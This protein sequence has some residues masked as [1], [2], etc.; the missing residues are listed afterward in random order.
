MKLR[1]LPYEFKAASIAA[2]VSLA[3]L[4]AI[5]Y[6]PESQRIEPIKVEGLNYTII[7]GDRDGDVDKIIDLRKPQNPV[8]YV[9]EDMV[10]W[11]KDNGETFIDYISRPPIPTPQLLE[12]ANAI[13]RG[14]SDTG[15]LEKQLEELEVRR[16]N[17]RR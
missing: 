14:N 8:A 6:I 17:R 5:K 11:F 9:T 10:E 2:V 15:L 4:I 16:L 13:L 7:D 12:T 3:G 1:D